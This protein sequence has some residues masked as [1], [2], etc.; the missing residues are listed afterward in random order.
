MSLDLINYSKMR[1]YELTSQNAQSIH[2]LIY[3]NNLKINKFA[4]ISCLDTK[5]ME[6]NRKF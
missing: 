3:H 2:A 5:L 1:N 6:K 4:L